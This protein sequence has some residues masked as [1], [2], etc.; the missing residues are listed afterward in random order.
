MADLILTKV[1][2]QLASRLVIARRSL[3]AS[4]EETGLQRVGVFQS[5]AGEVATVYYNPATHGLIWD[6]GT[7][8]LSQ[9]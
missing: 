4:G 6:D 9:Q 7:P 3:N 5:N 2:G 8:V 1:A